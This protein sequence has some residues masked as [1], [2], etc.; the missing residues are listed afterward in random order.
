[1]AAGEGH[2][3]KRLS[4]P[5]VRGTG[6]TRRLQ[7]KKSCQLVRA[8]NSRIRCDLRR[9]YKAGTAA[10]GCEQ[11]PLVM[12]ISKGRTHIRTRADPPRARRR[13]LLLGCRGPVAPSAAARGTVD[14][15]EAGPRC[16]RRPGAPRRSSPSATAPATAAGRRPSRGA[17]PSRRTACRASS[18]RP[19]A[20][21][22]SPSRGT[23]PAFTSAPSAPCCS[24]RRPSATPARAPR[25]ATQRR[26]TSA[27]APPTSRST[28]ACAT[29][30]R[31]M[32]GSP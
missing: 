24:S 12:V 4:D 31:L 9:T 19:R 10:L 6:L 30:A 16:S 8:A 29:S 20:S 1:M 7:M 23:P 2:V 14:T 11:S 15:R 32:S 27:S 5:E 13:K 26:A 25:A 17:K 3:D 22:P 21:R 28:W 18:T